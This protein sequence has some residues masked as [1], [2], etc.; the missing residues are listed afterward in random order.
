[1]ART[2]ATELCSKRIRV[3]IIHPGWIDT[4][5][6]RKFF[7]EEKLKALNAALALKQRELDLLMAIDEIRDTVSDP[8]A[9]LASITSLL[10]EELKV[11]D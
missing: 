6:E 4:P 11:G 2:A 7:S 5:G 8:G 10:A 9:M 1:M 3:N